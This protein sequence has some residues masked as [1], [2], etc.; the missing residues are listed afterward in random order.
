MV[1]TEAS[2]ME[3]LRLASSPIVPHVAMQNSSIG[4]FNVNKNT[5]IMFNTY[6]L[7]MSEDY[8]FEPKTFEPTR[9]LSPIQGKTEEATFKSFKS[10]EFLKYQI[11]RPECY[12]PFS[13]G[14][15][16]CLGYKMVQTITFSTVANLMLNYSIRPIAG[17]Y[18]ELEKQ[19][20]PKGC[21]AL[22]V[23]DC[24]DLILIPR[25]S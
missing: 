6:N 8:H 1:Y 15:R 11:H 21:L 22:K 9:F 2:M 10:I 23:D 25:N 3:T 4:D 16:A 20:E 14:K 18:T 5:Y 24:F 17:G 7:N 19:L 12:F 13:W